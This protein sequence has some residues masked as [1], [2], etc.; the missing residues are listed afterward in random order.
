MSNVAR[1]I[2]NYIAMAKGLDRYVFNWDDEPESLAVL[3]D[4][5]D[6]L[7]K[8]PG[9]NFDYTDASL[10]KQKARE[11]CNKPVKSG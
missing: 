6:R 1:N 10:L 9:L 3:D 4:A 8:N 5:F 2:M 7:A 11:A